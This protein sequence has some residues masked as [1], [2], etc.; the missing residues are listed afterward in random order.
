M[1]AAT[2]R[3]WIQP[4]TRDAGLEPE[5]LV[6]VMALMGD[7]S[8]EVPGVRRVRR[9]ALLLASRA[10][11]AGVESRRLTRPVPPPMCTAGA[12]GRRTR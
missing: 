5:Q 8:D 7:A 10:A 1:L 2:T 9:R 11:A 3:H 12:L 6:D 4:P